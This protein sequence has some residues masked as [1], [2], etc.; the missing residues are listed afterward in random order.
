MSESS[1]KNAVQAL[2]RV[3]GGRCGTMK[4]VRILA[5]KS[6]SQRIRRRKWRSIIARRETS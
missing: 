3:D 6:L 1:V 4:A 5:N 2:A